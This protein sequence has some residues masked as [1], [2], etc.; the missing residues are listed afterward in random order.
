MFKIDELVFDIFLPPNLKIRWE[1]HIDL[2]LKGLNKNCWKVIECDLQLYI[3]DWEWINSIVV[4]WGYFET[5][6]LIAAVE[7]GIK[8][9]Q[10]KR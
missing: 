6:L 9:M 3:P 5:L 7:S 2:K 1:N 10:Q 8:I 4:Y